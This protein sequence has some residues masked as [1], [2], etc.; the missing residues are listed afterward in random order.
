MKLEGRNLGKTHMKQR[1]QARDAINISKD[2][3]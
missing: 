2:T 3:G 1:L